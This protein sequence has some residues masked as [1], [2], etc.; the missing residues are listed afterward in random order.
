[1][2]RHLA[3]LILSVIAFQA[4]PAYGQVQHEHDLTVYVPPAM[5][6]RALRP[7]QSVTHPETPADITMSNSLWWATTSSATGSTIRFTS[8][9]PFINQD[10]P[11]YKRDVRLHSPRLFGNPSAG[12]SFDTTTDQTDYAAGDDQAVVQI[13]G[14]GPGIALIFLQVTFIT[15]NVATLAGGDYE[16]TV[17]GTITAN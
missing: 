2:I 13:S 17:V 7:D 10:R 4:A 9:T 12:W 14:T 11:S 6:L 8:D 3:I 1:M 15:G 5:S 16:V